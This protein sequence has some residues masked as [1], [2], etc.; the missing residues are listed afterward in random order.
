MA[1]LIN[2]VFTQIRFIAQDER[3][4]SY[5]HSD[6]KIMAYF[7]S[8]VED[9]RRIRP[10]LFLASA[11]SSLWEPI[12][13]FTTD[14]LDNDTEI[15]I[16]T[17][18]FSALVDYIAGHLDIEDDEFANDGRAIALLNRFAQKLIAKGA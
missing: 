15:P 18:Y 2:E 16:D 9:V 7:N 1:R 6:E 10:D 5:R 8:A 11:V 17:M 14:D 12:P 3:S 13:T 4:E